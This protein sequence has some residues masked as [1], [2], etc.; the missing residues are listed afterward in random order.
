M[1]KIVDFSYGF[2]V[3]GIGSK[4]ELNTQ[5]NV[6]RYG[7]E[8]QPTFIAKFASNGFF[9]DFTTLNLAITLSREFLSSFARNLP[10][11]STP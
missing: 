8:L 1:R 3:C 6:L 11:K 7:L 4:F 5:V 10:E 2:L 9:P